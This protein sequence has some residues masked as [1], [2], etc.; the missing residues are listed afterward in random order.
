MQCGLSYCKGV[1]PSVLHTREM[2]QNERKF[3]R[4]S[5]TIWKENS[6]TFWNTKS[7]SWGTPPCTWNF[8]SNWSTQF[9]NASK[10]VIFQSIFSRSGW[11]VTPSGKSSIMT[12][13]KSPTRFPM[14]LRWTTYV[15]SNTQRG[16]KGNNFFRFPYKN[17]L[18]SKKVCYRFVELSVEYR[19][20]DWE[21]VDSS[22]GRAR[23]IETMGK[24]LTPMCLCSPSSISWYR[25][26]G[27]DA[28]RLGSKGRYC[29]CVGSR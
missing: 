26:K 9:Q 5:Y 2:W 20:C 11:A 28:L 24:F 23:G 29:S 7:G 1:R 15:A 27:G 22:L 14:S 3:R 17:W 6:S 18:C 4:H 12:N 25:P 21:V 8:R 16:I 19:T 13:G 10:M